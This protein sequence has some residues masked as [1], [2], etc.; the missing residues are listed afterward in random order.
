VGEVLLD[1]D[2]GTWMR[3]RIEST[4]GDT[5]LAEDPRSEFVE[6]TLAVPT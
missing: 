4:S 5:K 1:P 6:R 3:G 2:G